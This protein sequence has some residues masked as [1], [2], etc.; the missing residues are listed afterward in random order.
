MFCQG[1]QLNAAVSMARVQ[2][3][4]AQVEYVSYCGALCV[5]AV[6]EFSHMVLYFIL[7]V[8]YLTAELRK[9]KD[10]DFDNDWKLLTVLIGAN[11]ACPACK[12]RYVLDCRLLCWFCFLVCTCSDILLHSRGPVFCVVVCVFVC[13][14]FV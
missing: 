14:L 9:Y 10:I 3:L 2:E 1:A 7:R 4:P 5:P 13:F 11:N 12:N 8:S 6:D